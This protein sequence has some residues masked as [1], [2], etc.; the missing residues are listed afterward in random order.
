MHRFRFALLVGALVLTGF[1]AA[2]QTST[3]GIRGLVK[4]ETGGVLLGVTVEA[5]SPAR[6][7]A[8]AVEITNN[9]GL[10]RFEG[11]PV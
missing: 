5:S 9:Q 11:L 4:D 6:I 8:P 3:G 2:A 1:E 7:G 10:Y